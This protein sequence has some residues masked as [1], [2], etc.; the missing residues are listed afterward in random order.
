V[1]YQTYRDAFDDIETGCTDYDA[2]YDI[3]QVGATCDDSYLYFLWEILGEVGQPVITQSGHSN[4]AFWANLD[5]GESNTNGGQLGAEH[6]YLVQFAMQE[7]NVR[8]DWSGL[9]GAGWPPPQIYTLTDID[10]C[11]LGSY[12]E[13]RVPKSEMQFYGTD[14][15]VW[16]GVDVNFFGPGN[17]CMDQAGAF[18]LP[19][20]CGVLPTVI[21]DEVFTADYWGNPKSDFY[22]CHVISLEFKATNHTTPTLTVTFNWD[23]YDPNGAKVPDLSDDGWQ[24]DMDPGQEH[25]WW[26][27]A[28]PN[29]APEGMYTFTAS[30]SYGGQTHQRSTTFNVS[31]ATLSINLVRAMTTEGVEDGWHTGAVTEFAAN[32]RVYAWTLWDQ[33]IGTHT[34]TFRWYRPNSTLYGSW[35]VPFTSADD[36]LYSV[37]SWIQ[38][39]PNLN[40]GEWRVDIYMDGQFKISLNFDVVAAGQTSA[41]GA[42]T[43]GDKAPVQAQ[44]EPLCRP[45]DLR[46]VV[47][48]R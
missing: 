8:Y 21:I 20:A 48:G 40:L 4:F 15:E 46:T 35:D 38:G 36:C 6:E 18:Y 27:T 13:V 22:N 12:L 17:Q 44:S 14:I 1:T 29:D 47:G 26:I 11:I 30:A 45:S 42:K 3:H 19:A 7:G 28:I 16:M 2:Q 37:W 34:A 5:V 10:Y 43:G 24:V 41:S 39:S 31:Q 32:Q 23:T 25:Y 9:F 33:A